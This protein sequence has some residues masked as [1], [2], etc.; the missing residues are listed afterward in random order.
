MEQAKNENAPVRRENLVIPH[1]EVIVNLQVIPLGSQGEE[2]RLFLVLFEEVP[3]ADFLAHDDVE[4]LSPIP[5]NEFLKLQQEL[6]A[7][8][9]RLVTMLD[10][11]QQYTDEIQSAQEENL[12]NLEEVQS[13]NEELETAKEE[14]QSTNEEL[15]TV[16]EELQT[17]NSDLQRASDF[18]TSIVETV[19]EPLVVLD[20]A[21]RVKKANRAFY[22]TFRLSEQDTDT[23][24]IFELAQRA[25]DTPALRALLRKALFD[26]TALEEVELEHEFPQAGRK[27]L[28]INARRLNGGEMILL[29]IEDITERK[30]A[31]GELRRVQDEL[32]QGQKMEAIGR[33]AGGVAHDFNNMLTAILGFSQ[34][35][36]ESLE[37]GTEAHHEAAEIQKAGERAA[38]LTHQLLAFSRRQVLHPQVLS[39][40]TM[41]L[42]MEQM[43]RRLIGDDI[44]LDKTL[45]EELW[46][47][48]ADPGQM[49]QVILNLALNARDAMRSGG[50]LSI[51]T[52]NTHVNETGEQIRGL[53]PGSYV[54]LT[55]TDSGTGMDE[56]TQQ[57]IFE[58][59]FTTK[60][61]GSG[62]GLGLATVSGIVKQSG[63]SIRF[64][65][66][67]E[68]G[69]TFWVDFPR[70]EVGLAIGAPR[71]RAEMPSGT[72]TVL[73]AEDQDIVRGLAVR[74]LKRQG[75]TVL[76]AS[77]GSDALALCQSH[78][79]QIDL[80]VTD[81][82]MP[83]GLNGRQLAEQA[84]KIH[85]EMRV[86]LMSGY[87]TDHLVHSGI[88]KGAP[89]LQK[90][91]TPQQLA[92]KVRDVL[93]GSADPSY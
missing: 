20:N 6:I 5:K 2:S 15:S 29:S 93:D 41:I 43:L 3:Q 74:I 16:N 53:A 1:E 63:G 57:H 52:A 44:A 4:K 37:E 13:F 28:C 58:P 47:M 30:Q 39:L 21:L 24:G 71:G 88:E 61:E 48:N 73:V 64:A 60:P 36:V 32:R 67:L 11:Q 46:P 31:D 80:L 92:R 87:T 49:S 9:E 19:R 85:A 90:P 45:V 86:L 17:R 83:G 42:E 27:V 56:E 26:N 33:L 10:T 59:F 55:V 38:T 82:L 76:E 62:T 22:L 84:I 77:Q 34:M 75:Y 78:P 54:T 51:R 68:R 12:S 14:L 23:C 91:F 18:V 89:F 35:L 81:V 40:N 69:T 7:T 8:R 25:W 50:S 72:E 65:S 66:E 79:S 70:A